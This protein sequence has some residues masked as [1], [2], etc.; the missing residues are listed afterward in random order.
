M[1]KKTI[2]LCLLPLF[3]VVGCDGDQTEQ[4]KSVDTTTN[5]AVSDEG[6]YTTKELAALTDSYMQAKEKG[7]TGTPDEW[8]A[9][10]QLNQTDPAQ[11]AKQAEESGFSGGEMM[12]GAL[13]GAAVGAL[14]ANAMSNRSNMASNTYSAQ[15]VNNASN[16]AYS[17][18]E[19]DRNYGG[20]YV[21]PP[22]NAGGASTS[23]N[24]SSTSNTRPTNV[25]A[26]PKASTPTV[27]S[28]SR[29]GFGSS[30]GG[31]SSAGG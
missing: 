27:T 9:L 12:L 6:F 10:M 26:A 29:G 25:T 3:T 18:P 8:F 2:A 23:S 31:G 19:K 24:L 7:Y 15:R 28:V 22:T 5:T 20:T 16:Y 4:Y 14:A 1:Q 11:A 17:Q 13:A 21:P 30:Y